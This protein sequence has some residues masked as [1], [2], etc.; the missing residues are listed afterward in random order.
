[1]VP[2]SLFVHLR[3]H[4]AFSLAEGAIKI[5]DLVQACKANAMPAVALT[6]TGHLFGAM[7]F[8]LACQKAGIQP[9]IGCQVRLKVHREATGTDY[10]YDCV[11]LV[12]NATGYGNLLK[13]VSHSFLRPDRFDPTHVT[14]DELQVRS[15]G[16]ICLSGGKKGPLNQLLLHSIS[17]AE[18]LCKRFNSLFTNH[19][20]IEVGR[21]EEANEQIVEE[22]LIDLAYRFDIPLV[23][24]NEAFYVHKELFEAHDALLCI[25]DGKHITDLE[26]RRETPHHY[27]KSSDD[28]HALF[29][30]LPEALENTVVIAKR[31]AFMVETR[32]PLLPPFPSERSEED[33]L[34]IQAQEGLENRL[35]NLVFNE[36]M[37]D[38]EKTDLRLQYQERLDYERGIIE[39]MGFA[40]YY[41]IVA[42]FIKWS[43]SQDIPVG[44]GRGSGAGS[45]VAWCLTI[46]DIDPI[47][48]G[49]LFE[50]F[51]N[52]ERVSM[53]DFDVDFCQDRRDEVI[54]YVR[55]RYGDDR[56]AQIITFGKLQAKAVVRDVGRVLGL[57]YGYVDKVSKLI[58]N[59]PANPVTLDEAIAG[60]PQLQAMAQEDP[61]IEKLLDIG[62]KLEGLYRHASTHAAGVVIGGQPLDTLVPLYHD[63]ESP[64]P[65]TQFHMKHVEMAGL[66]KFDFLGLKT[67]S[68]IQKVVSLLKK[69]DIFLDISK[70][71]LDDSKTFTLLQRV[72]AV[73]IFQLESA[74]MK[75]VMRRLHPQRFEEL[76]AL[77]ALY[78]P[79]PMDDIPRYLAC[80]HGDEKVNYG[81]PILEEILKETFGVM[82]YQEQ[83]MQIAQV[84]SGYSLGEADL[85]R[86]AMGKKIKSEMD[87]QAD[88][89]IK[90]AVSKGVNASVAKGIFDQ[91]AKFAGYGFNKCHSAPY[92]LIAYQTAYLKANYPVEFMAA[93]MTYDL[94][95]TDKITVFKEDLHRMGISVLTPDVNA[96][97]PEFSVEDFEGSL[98]VRYALSAIKGVGVVAMKDVI[99]ERDTNGPFTSIF[100]FVRR[101]DSKAVNRRTLEKLIASGAFDRL[102]PSRSAMMASVN[103]ILKY[104][105]ETKSNDTNK[106]GSLFAASPASVPKDPPLIDSHPWSPLELLDYEFQAMGFYF[107]S[108]PLNAY[109]PHLESLKLKMSTDFPDLF[110]GPDEPTVSVAAVVVAKKERISKKGNRYAFVQF[111]DQSGVFE[112]T[113]FSELYTQYRTH[114]EPGSVFYLRITGKIEEDALRLTVQDAQLLEDKLKDAWPTLTLRIEAA[115]VFS[116]I[117]DIL[118]PLSQGRT[119]IRLRLKTQP[120]PSILL[121][122][123]KVQMSQDICDRLSMIPG[124]SLDESLC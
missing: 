53:P 80:K 77:V 74:G 17:E 21:Y 100:D 113:F 54:D 88:L 13:L 4:S 48:F 34:R 91:A 90:G 93:S 108:H 7:E 117:H 50:R 8:S 33:E 97:Y 59:N 45:L 15:E 116:R 75:D 30:D 118:K 105:G 61:Q 79:G 76:I 70:I 62:K 121:L 11:L 66:V 92:A 104:V 85:L 20:Y 87:A 42:D 119:E 12:Q 65:A 6:D 86:R 111:S 18:D 14:L 124:V 49:L 72:E 71:P 57:P 115:G 99:E 27:F 120:Y 41:L 29:A 51:L 98:A 37:N 36:S 16:L 35:K 122:G 9:I 23:A 94:N 84:L 46:T 38:T 40:G 26:R 107:S 10:F 89:F 22:Q 101:L 78:R 123:G 106:Q 44:P 5:P 28:M 55:R 52:P 114:L 19:F 69:R 43:K 39:R 112:V 95:N 83:V 2:L 3:V 60:E 103:E 25:A 73:G 58:P 81:H 68:V 102:H 47:R 32:A 96:S 24:T 64:L 82:V 109:G 63:G 31:C 56:V 1:M 110:K 67:L